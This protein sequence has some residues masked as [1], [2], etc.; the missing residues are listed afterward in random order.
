MDKWFEVDMKKK[1]TINVTSASERLAI[2][3][4][5]VHNLQPRERDSFFLANAPE[6]CDEKM[7]ERKTWN[8]RE[9]IYKIDMLHHVPWILMRMFT[10]IYV[11]SRKSSW[12]S[13]AFHL[14]IT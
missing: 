3:L 12:D 11:F 4:F 6:N 1:M 2:I 13:G 14:I 7:K 8:E 10:H 9:I 5:I